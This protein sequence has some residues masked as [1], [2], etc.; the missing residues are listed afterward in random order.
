[1]ND[2]FAPLESEEAQQARVE[3]WLL[4]LAGPKAAR[5]T[6]ALHASVGDRV[7]VWGTGEWMIRLESD[8]EPL[9]I[10]KGLCAVTG[11]PVSIGVA[12]GTTW[13]TSILAA[14]GARAL[15]EQ[16]GGDRVRMAL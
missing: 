7:A 4:S 1:M 2:P 15:A 11:F 14:Q 16:A 5:L 10:A 9:P 6:R 13:T 8:L 12:R 3:G